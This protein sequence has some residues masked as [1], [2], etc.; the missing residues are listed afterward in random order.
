[1]N[2]NA[3]GHH[4]GATRRDNLKYIYFRTPALTI[5][6]LYP[7]LLAQNTP[8][9]ESLFSSLATRAIALTPD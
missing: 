6:S 9:H 5:R 3:P 8:A 4:S 2:N 7:P 1:M